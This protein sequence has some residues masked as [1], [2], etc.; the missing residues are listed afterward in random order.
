MSRNSGEITRLNISNLNFSTTEAELSD[1]FKN[2]GLI[3]V[4]I[5]SQ[6]IRGF[7]SNHVR[8]LGIGYAEF[9]SSEKVREAIED[10]NGKDFKGRELR[11]KPYVPYS[12]ELAARKMSRSKTLSKLRYMKKSHGTAEN[13]STTVEHVDSNDEV[14]NLEV[15]TLENGESDELEAENGTTVEQVSSTTADQEAEGKEPEF[16]DDTVYVGYL[17]KGCTDVELREYFKVFKPQEIWIF[18]TRPTKSR[19]LQFR[20]HFVA[21][22]VRLKTPENMTSIIESTHKKKLLGKKIIVKPAIMRKLQDMKKMADDKK[23]LEESRYVVIEE[24]HLAEEEQI[25]ETQE[26]QQPADTVEGIVPLGTE[27]ANSQVTDEIGN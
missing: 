10:L 27:L 13:V 15:T 18:R 17:P 14:D 12:P 3:S 22:L 20:R 24:E 19:H 7:R 5:P 25:I 6:T 1:Y 21:A 2:Y 4:L 26:I 16:S 9:E 23:R 8:P 11:L